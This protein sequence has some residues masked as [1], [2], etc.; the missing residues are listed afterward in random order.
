M[1]QAL[2]FGSLWLV[3]FP[4]CAADEVDGRGLKPSVVG[5]TDE[6]S[7]TTFG[8]LLC[9]RRL[10]APQQ[11]GPPCNQFRWSSETSK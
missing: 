2:L 10:A 11:E 9:G 7:A 8:T 5:V 4:H 1:C 3:L 6:S